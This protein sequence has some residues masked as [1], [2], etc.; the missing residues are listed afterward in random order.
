[1]SSIKM[2]LIPS[3][4]LYMGGN[5]IQSDPNEYPNHE[6]EL[7]SFYMDES[8]VTNKEFKK[9]ID[10][11]GYITIAERKIDWDEM[12]KQLPPYTPRPHDSIMAPGALV[13]AGT[14]GPVSFNDPNIWWKWTIGASWQ[15]PEG[16]KSDIKKKNNHPV[17]H[18]AWEDASAY[19]KWAKKRLPTEAEW[20]WAGRGGIE[21]MIY[22]WGNEKVDEGKVKGNFFQGLFPYKNTTKDGYLTTAPVKSF[23]PN[24]Y[25]LYDM[26]GNVWEWCNDWYDVEYYS[27]KSARNPNSTGPSKAYNPIAPYQQER[28]VRGG[29]FLCSEEYCSGYRS[30]RRMGSTPD[31]GLNHTGCRCVRDNT[32]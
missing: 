11:T 4:T 25:G 14:T 6:I 15:H 7:S 31:T 29:S 12:K 13:F 8:E 26:A 21:K 5:N 28:V 23:S 30:A 1:M 17:V 24:G 3:G 2:L 9:F 16:P 10:E 32:Q 19:C 27:K 20:E 18:I 22:P